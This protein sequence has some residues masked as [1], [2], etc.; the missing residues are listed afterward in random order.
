MRDRVGPR[1]WRL[2]GRQGR[3]LGP[4]GA[5][6]RETRRNRRQ[7]IVAGRRRRGISG[8]R[9]LDLRGKL[10]DRVERAPGRRVLGRLQI[11]VHLIVKRVQLL[12]GRIVLARGRGRRQIRV[13]RF[14]PEPDARE[15]MRRHVKRV[16]RIG[17][18]LRVASS[19]IER[20]RRER[21]HIEAVD[22]VVRETWMVGLRV[23]SASSMPAAFN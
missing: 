16:G 13:D 3:R 9:R 12:G 23:Y 6:E 21:R 20:A 19:G 2:S 1:S 4:G 14:L 7:R 5:L 18:N 22:D 17:R 11:G 8:T 10:T 15:R